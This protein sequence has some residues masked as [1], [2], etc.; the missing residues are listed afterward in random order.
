MTDSPTSPSTP[1]PVPQWDPDQD[2]DN[3][4][5]VYIPPSRQSDDDD[6]E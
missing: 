5:I 2:P 4:Q 3:C 6:D 1:D